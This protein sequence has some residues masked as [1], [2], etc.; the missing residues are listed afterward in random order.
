MY[1]LF[2]EKTLKGFLCSVMWCQLFWCDQYFIFMGNVKNIFYCYY[3]K[4]PRELRGKNIFQ[5]P[6]KWN[7]LMRGQ[8]IFE[9]G[10]HLLQISILQIRSW[11]SF[12]SIVAVTLWASCCFC[13]FVF[14]QSDALLFAA[15][16]N[17]AIFQFLQ[18]IDINSTLSQWPQPLISISIKLYS[19]SQNM[20]YHFDS[21]HYVLKVYK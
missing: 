16:E 12:S 6:M 17:L 18:H 9:T 11:L 14:K 8:P 5:I 21:F 19:Q 1:F 13:K 2:S 10:G 3:L 4:T 20:Y 7:Y 15:L